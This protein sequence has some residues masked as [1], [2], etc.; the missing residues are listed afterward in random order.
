MDTMQEALVV[1][2]CSNNEAKVISYLTEHDGSFQR[3]IERAC[4]LR[5]PEV[6]I[7]LSS[8]KKLGVIQF[9]SVHAVRG[10]SMKKYSLLRNRLYEVMQEKFQTE[11]KIKKMAVDTIVSSLY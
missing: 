3:D 5:Q 4:D 8:L 9:E 11:I 10:R 6:S 1:L 2:G 7:A